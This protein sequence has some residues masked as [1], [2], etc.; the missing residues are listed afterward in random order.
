MILLKLM[1]FNAALQ[2]LEVPAAMPHYWL[3]KSRLPLHRFSSE[4]VVEAHRYFLDRISS[5]FIGS[6]T[7]SVFNRWS[8]S[9]YSPCSCAC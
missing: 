1:T 8:A 2:F 4:V 3:P 9:Q 6:Y 7:V 5:D